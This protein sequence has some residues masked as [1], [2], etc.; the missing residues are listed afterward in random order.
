[1]KMQ[2]KQILIIMYEDNKIEDIIRFDATENNINLIKEV[3]EKGVTELKFNH[4]SC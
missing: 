3:I 1:M 4:F 2:K